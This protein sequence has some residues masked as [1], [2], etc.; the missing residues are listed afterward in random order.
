MADPIFE[1]EVSRSLRRVSNVINVDKSVAIECKKE[2]G[3]S[4]SFDRVNEDQIKALVEFEQKAFSQKM[5]VSS[6]VGGYSRFKLKSGFDFLCCPAGKSYVLV[7]FRS[8]KKSAGKEIPKGTNRCFAVRIS[9]FVRGQLTLLS[10]GRKS[11][12]YNWFEHNSLELNRIKWTEGDAYVYG[13]DLLP[14]FY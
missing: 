1:P 11:F 5:L 10:E 3:T 2:S 13:W 12:P 8:T 4:L 6:S 14:L 7:N 9:E